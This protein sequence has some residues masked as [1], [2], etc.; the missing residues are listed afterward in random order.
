[1]RD[2][3]IKPRPHGPLLSLAP[4]ERGV[5]RGWSS[6]QAQ[7]SGKI[8]AWVERGGVPRF[9]R[10]D[11]LFPLLGSSSLP[12]GGMVRPILLA[13]PPLLSSRAWA[14]PPSWHVRLR[15]R[16]K[17]WL[18]GGGRTGG[19]SRGRRRALPPALLPSL[20]RCGALRRPEASPVPVRPGKEGRVRRPLPPRDGR[21]HPGGEDSAW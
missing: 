15:E 1:M 16:A 12:R 20:F 3:F 10:Q 2:P 11:F 17:P 13:F 5:T 8:H 14:P 6:L 19:P 21:Y 7:G 18:W 4:G 9:S